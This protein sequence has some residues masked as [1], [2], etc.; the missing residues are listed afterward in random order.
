MSLNKVIS[1]LDNFI[2]R[3]K[4]I[5]YKNKNSLD[6]LKTYGD[7]RLIKK[8][9]GFKKI[10]TFLKTGLQNTVNY[11]ELKLEIMNKNSKFGLLVL[12]A[13]LEKNLIN[14]LKK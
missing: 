14:I 9:T 6:S 7:N 13:W 4:K 3:P 11:F 12:M 5:I 8:I 2:N 1:I 10:Y